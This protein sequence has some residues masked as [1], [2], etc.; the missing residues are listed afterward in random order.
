MQKPDNTYIFSDYS[1]CG[2]AGGLV[3]TRFDEKDNEQIS[4]SDFLGRLK[5]ARELSPVS[6]QDAKGEENFRSPFSCL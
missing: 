4:E 1:V 2:C 5:D 3:N 6:Y